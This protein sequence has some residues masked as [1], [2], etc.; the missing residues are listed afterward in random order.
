METTGDVS[1]RDTRT[2]TRGRQQQAHKPPTRGAE[3]AATNHTAENSGPV[4]AQ[5]NSAPPSAS[6]L[7]S[8]FVSEFEARVINFMKALDTDECTR[9]IAALR[10][11][12]DAIEMVVAA[13][14]HE[15]Q[16]GAQDELPDM[17]D[18]L[19]RIAP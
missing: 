9:L 12:I 18:F 11:N 1:L 5:A 10:E 2:D 14:S 4:E 15:P 16:A 6:Y 19:Q 17:P 3:I 7:I 13:A 8:R